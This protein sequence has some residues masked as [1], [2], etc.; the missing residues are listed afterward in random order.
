MGSLWRRRNASKSPRVSAS[1]G[2]VLGPQ[3]ATLGA[4]KVRCC[5]V[6]IGAGVA[7]RVLDAWSWKLRKWDWK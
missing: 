1:P 3:K 2:E 5:D 7:R 6:Q 4:Q